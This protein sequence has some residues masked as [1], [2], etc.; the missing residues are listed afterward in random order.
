MKKNQEKMTRLRF[1]RN[2][3]FLN[4]RLS[5]FFVP[6]IGIFE[7]QKIAQSGN[8]ESQIKAAL[9][10]SIKNCLPLG[11]SHGLVVMG[12]DS[13]SKGVGFK[14]GAVYVMDIFHIDLL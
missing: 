9:Y 3:H 4:E 2:R 10:N 11:G 14:S 6:K 5:I 7:F 1:E 13:C 12:D 8:N